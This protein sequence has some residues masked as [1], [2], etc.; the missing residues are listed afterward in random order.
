MIIQ[1]DLGDSL[2]KAQR[3][4]SAIAE[5]STEADDI[6]APAIKEKSSRAAALVTEV[7]MLLKGVPNN[8]IHP[9]LNKHDVVRLLPVAEELWDKYSVHVDTDVD[10]FQSVAGQSLLN[11]SDFLKLISELLSNGQ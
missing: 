5:I 11:R 3:L 7:G 10:S 8:D 1:I 6:L 4:L 9:Q 2:A